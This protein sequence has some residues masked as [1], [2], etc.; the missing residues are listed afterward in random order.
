MR[1]KKPPRP[2]H[3]PEILLVLLL[4]AGGAIRLFDKTVLA[5]CRRDGDGLTCTQLG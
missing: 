5:F 2:A 3:T 4:L 1:K